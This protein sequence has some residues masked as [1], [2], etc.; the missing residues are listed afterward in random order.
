M[1]GQIKYIEKPSDYDDMLQYPPESLS[2]Y[3]KKNTEDNQ[4]RQ[5]GI[6]EKYLSKPIAINKN[7]KQP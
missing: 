7:K 4:G 3:T 6:T 2:K 1:H 5:E